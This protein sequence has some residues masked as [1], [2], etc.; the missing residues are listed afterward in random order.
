[1]I[2]RNRYV[3]HVLLTLVAWS[4]AGR[5]RAG[6]VSGG[7]YVITAGNTTAGPFVGTLSRI[8]SSGKLAETA[9]TGLQS[10]WGFAFV[11]ADVVDVTETPTPGG[12]PATSGQLNTYTAE[13]TQIRSVSASRPPTAGST[14]PGPSASPS[15]PRATPT[16]P[17]G[18]APGRPR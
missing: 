4:H 8:D 18:T 2:P 9:L 11:N 6:F 14:A 7:L 17:P 1:M 10:P 13:G 12:V 5:A 15:M 3:A 16:S